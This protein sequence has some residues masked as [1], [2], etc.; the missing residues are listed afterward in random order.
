VVQRELEL[1]KAQSM[2][3][4]E[5]LYQERDQ[6]RRYQLGHEY[7]HLCLGPE[8]CIQRGSLRHS[9]RN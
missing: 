6:V 8:R 9:G 2:K 7:K 3:E 4:Y 1:A 5:Q